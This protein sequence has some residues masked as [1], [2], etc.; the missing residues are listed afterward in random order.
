MVGPVARSQLPGPNGC[1]HDAPR[2]PVPPLPPVPQIDRPAVGRKTRAPGSRSAVGDAGI[3]RRIEWTL[4]DG[5]VSGVGDELGEL[6]VGDR[7]PFD[8][9]AIATVAVCTGASSG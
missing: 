5:H 9:E 1:R 7:M 2:R 8:R 4:R 3:Q 6:R